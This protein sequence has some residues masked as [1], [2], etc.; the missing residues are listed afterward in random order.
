[1]GTATVVF[2]ESAVVPGGT[3]TLADI[4][5]A[6]LQYPGGGYVG[7]PL[8]FSLSTQHLF[9]AVGRFDSTA[10]NFEMSAFFSLSWIAGTQIGD[11]FVPSAFIGPTVTL[12]P[13]LM[14]W[15]VLA[16]QPLSP[17][18]WAFD[19]G[20]GAWVRVPELPSIA[21]LS[22]GV[23]ASAKLLF[24]EGT[25][26]G[27]NLGNNFAHHLVDTAIRRDESRRSPSDWYKSKSAAKPS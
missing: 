9:D 10:T 6:E 5:S 7:A 3:F 27:V 1:M 13:S 22:F 19:G 18:G 17:I 16:P 2:K 8:P 15:T 21:L 26:G 25:R 4:L 24:R 12:D 14:H 23:L 20:A 11:A